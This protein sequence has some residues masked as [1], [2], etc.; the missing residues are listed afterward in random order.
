MSDPHQY[1]SPERMYQ[2]LTSHFIFQNLN[3][4]WLLLAQW[5]RGPFQQAPLPPVIGRFW[6]KRPYHS[7]WSHYSVWFWPCQ[8]K[9]KSCRFTYLQQK[10]IPQYHIIR[11]LQGSIKLLWQVFALIFVPE[12]CTLKRKPALILYPGY[13]FRASWTT[14]RQDFS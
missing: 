13:Q 8:N 3:S 6:A 7:L 9:G 12:T 2:A 4:Y 10:R 1:N 5:I 11:L 14:N